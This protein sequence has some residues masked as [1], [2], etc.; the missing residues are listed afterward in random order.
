MPGR[1][2][3]DMED[4]IDF[5]RAINEYLKLAYTFTQITSGETAE[6]LREFWQ[7]DVV[8]R[9]TNLWLT[10]GEY[11]EWISFN[12]HMVRQ[13]WGSTAGGWPGMGGA[14][15][16]EYYTTVIENEYYGFV[17]VYYGG[18]LAYICEMDDKY[19]EY[20]GQRYRALPGI[21]E[22]R[23]KLTILYTGR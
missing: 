17:C 18:R 13:M 15:M 23:K 2:R 22:C 12:A 3:F 6:P 19:K 9:D 11:R 4:S 1:V 14:A 8:K 7:R 20:M 10:E 21:T 16:S 5:Q